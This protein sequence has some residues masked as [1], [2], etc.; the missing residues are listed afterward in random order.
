[1]CC[2]HQPILLTLLFGGTAY[3][4]LLLVLPQKKKKRC[5]RDLLIQ[6]EQCDELKSTDLQIIEVSINT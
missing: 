6:S 1:M 3:I 5:K 2:Y 4:S